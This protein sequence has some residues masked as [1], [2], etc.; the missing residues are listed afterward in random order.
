MPILWNELFYFTVFLS[1]HS[2]IKLMGGPA[3]GQMAKSDTHV[4]FG[5]IEKTRSGGFALSQRGRCRVRQ[6]R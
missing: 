2:G 6:Q 4:F 5:K 1:Y 3:C